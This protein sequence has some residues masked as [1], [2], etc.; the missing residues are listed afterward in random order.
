MKNKGADQKQLPSSNFAFRGLFSMDV[1]RL[2]FLIWH[3]ASQLSRGELSPSELSACLQGCI[4]ILPLI[5]L[6]PLL[7]LYLHVLFL[8]MDAE[9][10][11]GSAK[12]YLLVR[13]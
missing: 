13:P 5:C 9:L 12:K 11:R 8:L 3:L 10:P 4:Y 7:L 2:M 6:H 1:K